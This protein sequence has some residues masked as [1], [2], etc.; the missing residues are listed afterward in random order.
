MIACTTL[1]T[2]CGSGGSGEPET[3]QS[4]PEVNQ[5][6]PVP[7]A[8]GPLPG[9]SSNIPVQQPPTRTPPPAGQSGG[10]INVPV[11]NLTE[12]VSAAPEQFRLGAQ[13]AKINSDMTAWTFTDVM[14]TSGKTG[15]SLDSLQHGWFVKQAKS[16]DAQLSQKINVD[17]DG[18]PVS[19]QLK[20]GDRAEA[21]FTTVMTA[22]IDNAYAP[23]IYT[24][25]FEGEGEF[26]FENV[27]IVDQQAGQIQL[28]YAGQGAVTVSI[29]DTDPQQSGNYLRNLRLLRPDSQND[30]LF[31]QEY[32]NYLKSAKVIRPTQWISNAALYGVFDDEQAVLTLQDWNSRVKLTHS[33]WG[34]GSGAP[35]ELM[36]ELANQSASHLWLNVPLAAGDDYIKSLATLLHS[37]LATNRVLYL[38][39]GNELSKRTF[40]QRQGRDYALAQA[41]IRWPDAHGAPAMENLSTL[42]QE[43]MLISNWQAA[44]TL[45]IAALF[46]DIWG[47]DAERVVSVLAGTV[48]DTKSPL[49]YNQQLLEGALITHFEQSQAPGHLIDSLAV[50]PLVYNTSATQFSIDNAQAMLTDTRQFVDGTG[51]FYEQGSAPGLRYGIRQAATLVSQYNIALTAYAGGHGFDASSYLNYQVIKSPEMYDLYETVFDVWNEESGGVFVAGKGITTTALPNYCNS[52][53]SNSKTM[54]TSIGLKETMRQSEQEAHM[55]RAWRDQMRKIG[56]IK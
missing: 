29:I 48:Q 40:P 4:V 12:T 20:N 24:F 30:A 23:G 3:T 18:W 43:N 13:L 46:D 5:A 36:A 17:A 16:F 27:S 1:I 49:T 8:S 19:M 7:S 15:E 44:R 2:A 33:H 6:T 10:L 55:Y 38:E 37:Q 26:E 14:K 35:Y 47:N 50:D 25:T 11:G 45:E 54:Q 39:L 9:S 22:D 32:L 41:L 21:I 52:N 42:Q 51:R 53:N 56:Q 34:T 28:D 31:T